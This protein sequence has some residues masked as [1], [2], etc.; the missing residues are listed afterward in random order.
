MWWC[1]GGLKARGEAT[2]AAVAARDGRKE[3]RE[4]VDEGMGRRGDGVRKAWA[5]DTRKKRR[6]VHVPCAIL[7]EACRCCC[8]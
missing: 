4:E 2:A 3:L 7:R 8:C 1:A 6:K 5:V